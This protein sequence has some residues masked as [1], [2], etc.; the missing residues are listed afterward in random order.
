MWTHIVVRSAFKLHEVYIFITYVYRKQS[1]WNHTIIMRVSQNT[2]P[3]CSILCSICCSVYSCFLNTTSK[4]RYWHSLTLLTLCK[5]ASFLQHI[6]PKWELSPAP[7]Y[8]RMWSGFY[9]R[10]PPWR[11]P[12]CLRPAL[13]VHLWAPE[14]WF[15]P[16]PGISYITIKPLTKFKSQC[17]PKYLTIYYLLTNQQ[18]C[19]DTNVDSATEQLTRVSFPH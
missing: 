19:I 11:N 17:F 4:K 6:F 5:Q 10:C 3:R 8:P 9:T 15:A 7:L 14:A 12:P 18:K 16:P 1:K 13:G 2:S